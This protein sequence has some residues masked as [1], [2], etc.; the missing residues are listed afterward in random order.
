METSITSLQY[1]RRGVLG[2]NIEGTRSV[3]PFGFGPDENPL[4]FRPVGLTYH[5][6]MLSGRSVALLYAMM[7]M[8]NVLSGKRG[9]RKMKYLS[10]FGIALCVFTIVL[11]QSRIG[12]ASIVLPLAGLV[13]LHKATVSS[14][15]HELYKKASPYLLY[16]VP[17]IALAS[18]IL[19]DRLLYLQYIFAE[20]A[21]WKTRLLLI[22]EAIKL[23]V[24]YPWLGVGTGMFIPAAF[25]EQRYEN[26]PDISIMRYF[27]EGVHNGFLL[28]AA[29]NGIV[30]L[31]VFIGI[32]FLIGR[33]LVIGRFTFT[34][35][36]F[37]IAGIIANLIF[38][39][40]QPVGMNFPVNIIA[41]YLV[42]TYLYGK[43]TRT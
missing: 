16:F 27:P 10:W 38:M 28:L 4:Q 32:L 30:S 24:R 33:E 26:I 34:T 1:V 14:L 40:A 29:E 15:F 41:Y 6:N 18:F 42:S 5:A 36:S 17:F 31:L 11:T 9:G 39:T 25:N 2:L 7:L 12:Y 20:S 3:A 37:I 8:V 43:E 23:I 22:Q 19:T 35:K 13:F 21:G